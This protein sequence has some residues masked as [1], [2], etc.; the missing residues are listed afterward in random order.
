MPTLEEYH[1]VMTT[2]LDNRGGITPSE[3]HNVSKLVRQIL[4]EVFI[5][6]IREAVIA[7][8]VE[9]VD[10]EFTGRFMRFL[11]SIQT[12]NRISSSN[13]RDA[14]LKWLDEDIQALIAQSDAPRYRAL[15]VCRQF[16]RTYHATSEEEMYCV[17]ATIARVY[18]DVLTDRLSDSSDAVD[19]MWMTLVN[20]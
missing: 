11:D 12:G 3:Y 6:P 18:V 2:A 8:V 16:L 14:M 13:D 19:S 10:Y 9:A 7:E 1:L 5:N 20:S 17:N 15:W 4:G